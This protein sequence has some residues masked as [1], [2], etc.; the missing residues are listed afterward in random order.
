MDTIAK[1]IDEIIEKSNN[2]LIE[3]LEK[4]FDIPVYQNEIKE[5]ELKKLSK[6]KINVFIFETGGLTSQ[7]DRSMSQEVLLK[8]LSENRD[9][10]DIRMVKIALTVDAK[11]LYTFD[12]SV[13]T[14]VRKGDTDHYVDY[15]E[16]YFTRVIKHGC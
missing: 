16:F 4:A 9:D 10:L 11:P 7:N 3:T 5:D 2:Q 8:Y 14:R 6:K 12:R 13:K 15:I 1:T